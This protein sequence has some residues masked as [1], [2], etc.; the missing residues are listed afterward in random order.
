MNSMTHMLTAVLLLIALTHT[1]A[2]SRR[3]DIFSQAVLY[4]KRVTLE[5]DLRERITGYNMSLPLDS[6]S[7]DKYMSACW[8]ISQ[9][10]IY[11]PQVAAGFDTLFHGYGTL[12]YDTKRAFLEAVYAVSPQHYAKQI[13]SI[14]DNSSDPKLFSLCAAYLYRV[15]TGTGNSNALKIRMVE[16]FPGY[17]TIPVLQE[18]ANFLSY[19]TAQQRSRT[20]DL[21]SLFAYQRAK[22]QKII[23]SFQ[24]W[25]RNYPGMAIVQGED[26]QFIKDA[27]GRIQVFE[28]LARSGSDL[29]YFLTNGSTPQGVYSIQGTDVSR[30][31][32]IGPTPNIQLLMPFEG[33]W[34]KYFHTDT[35]TV[36]PLVADFGTVHPPL[37]SLQM[38]L[39]LLFP[40]DWQNYTPMMEAWSAGRI[41]RAEIIAHGT[42]IDPEYFKDRPFYPLTPT[43]GCLCAKELW[44][45]T[46][47]H[48][49]VSEQLNL[50]N[51]WLSTP[52][53]KGYLY[54]INIDDQ[55]KP[56]SRA[57][58]EHL[59]SPAS[60]TKNP[61]PSPRFAQTDYD[62]CIYG[63]TSAGVI[64]AYTAARMHKSVLLVEPGHHLGGLSSGGLG[65]T[66]I[67][68]KYAIKGLSLDFYRRVGRHYGKF[69]QWVFEP[70]VAE[71]IF[72]QYIQD[73]NIKTLY[74]YHIVGAT[75]Q[76]A[77]ITSIS[78]ESSGLAKAL[79]PRTI[80]AKMFID[81]SYEGDLMARA[82]VSY[83]VGRE[84]NTLYNETYNGIQLRDKHQ[85]PD[86]IDPYKTPGDRSGG[87]LWGI[88]PE[89]IGQQGQG[90]KKV[91]SYNYRICLTNDPVNRIPITRPAGYD[92]TRY[93]LLLRLLEKRPAGDLRGFLKFDRLP[94]HK[95]D[96]NNN[97]PFSTDN[98]GMNYDYPD[99]DYDT[100]K[101]I[102]QAHTVYTK[103]LLYFIGNDKRMPPHLRTQMQEWGYP[104]DE[105]ADNG[106][107]SPQMYVRE[108]RR[109]KGAYIMTQANCEDRT[110]VTDGVGLAAYTMD[111]HNCQRIVVNGMV[112]NEG[113]VQIGG[114]PPYPIS[115]RA[116]VPKTEECS[117]L[118]VP[119]CLS[120]SHIAYGS[121]RMEPVF[122]ELGQSSAIAA[123]MAI[124][125]H[126]PVQQ[127]DAAAIRD[128]LRNDPLADGSTPE[129]LVDNDD[130]AGVTVEG[131]WTR[132]TQDSY[133]F[134]RLS[135]GL[136]D[137]HKDQPFRQV[138]FNITVT[139]SGTYT[140]Y[141]YVSRT[142]NPS[143]I[144]TVT[145]SA[146]G[147][148][149]EAAIPTGK[150]RVE[151]QTSGEW[152]ECGR[153]PLKAGK[154][155]YVTINNKG[156]DGVIVADA[157]LLT[158]NPSR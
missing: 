138:R 27:Q 103:G 157:V 131:E 17:D 32:F 76:A 134:S 42:T 97:G 34:D 132:D 64:A 117:N 136:T 28:Q 40:P 151:G 153:Y 92:S 81:C 85:F 8:A 36:Q 30:T 156:A 38:Y 140:L 129:I 60:A 98:I 79:S 108:S 2:Q 133:G 16:K 90:D 145:V 37:D 146:G 63:G 44:N 25:D 125:R 124:D 95:T 101:K 68:N 139:V 10:L 89:P 22:G 113:D 21:S 107:W 144:T 122:M 80:K 23:Y 5:K 46:S 29:P 93:E 118:L 15:D 158:K 137:S 100:R 114:F 3:E 41:G 53:K 105:Y 135:S 142:Q 39:Q 43:M 96:I 65:Y 24:R 73:A 4:Q 111:S 52:A 119:V 70:H 112:K 106:H 127:V 94:G 154:G 84:A 47:G 59:L 12:S 82:G 147:K 49:L 31:S 50:L 109:M 99:A 67:G 56:V 13:R 54:V 55:H 6:N 116:L 104:K 61:D 155:N 20:P 149:T 57:E 87:L 123:A 110:T 115:Y 71:D 9:F 72:K 14:L 51:A 102:A 86:G 150:L 18:L 74:D 26:G 58:V 128:T 75:K 83:T 1:A 120:A 11:S 7:E 45:P 126:I 78:L 152:M 130:G 62:I 69:E 88:S 77:A 19:H 141:I 35:A 121:I 33:A 66:D 91:Q 143:K 48:P 148:V